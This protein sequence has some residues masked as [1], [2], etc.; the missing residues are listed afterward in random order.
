VMKRRG[1]GEGSIWKRADGRWAASID[2]GW[3]DGKRKRKFLYGRTRAEVAE[4]LRKA[5]HGIDLGQAPIDGRLTT[6]PFLTAW[7]RD[8]LPGS[9]KP[10]TVSNYQ[11]VLTHYVIPYVGRV[12]LAKLGPEHVQRMLRA[13]EEQGLSVRTRRIAR[14]V[15]RRA[16]GQAERWG[17]VNRNAAALVDCPRGM[18]IG[19]HDALDAAGAR[20]VLDAARGERLEALAVLALELGL[21]RGELLG[22]RWE[23][24]DLKAGELRVAHTLSYRAGVGL[25]LDEPKTEAGRRTIPLVGATLPALRRHRRRQLKER[26]AA[27]PHWSDCGHVFA[28]ELGGPMDPRNVLRWWYRVTERA[29]VGR[30]RLHAARHTA[31]T[32]LLEQGVPLEVVSAV[33]GH[34][35]L[36]ITAD[37]YARVC[38]DAKRKGLGALATV[39]GSR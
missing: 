32:L 22:L 24:I 4:K 37:V 2:L 8:T 12:P 28:N 27:G 31:A 18:H 19:T 39:I 17:K 34:A 26:L 38:M 7:A 35:S 16:L 3:E 30:R 6:G 21:R 11:D 10:S 25:V 29:G 5:Q 14:A 9:V 36:A 1:H 13:L 23:D 20:A 33:L 15:L